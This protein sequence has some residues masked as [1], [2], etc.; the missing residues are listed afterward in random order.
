MGIGIL[1]D[2]ISIPFF[3]VEQLR[4]IIAIMT[5]TPIINKTN[6]NIAP[7]SIKLVIEVTILPAVIMPVVII[8]VISVPTTTLL[9]AFSTALSYLAYVIASLVIVFIDETSA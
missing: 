2:I 9:E 4:L 8:L 7:Q 3:I 1:F 5:I 6:K